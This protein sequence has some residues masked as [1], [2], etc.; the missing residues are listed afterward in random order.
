MATVFGFIL[1]VFT[2]SFLFFNHI[3]LNNLESILIHEKSN[4]NIINAL[5]LL[6]TAIRRMGEPTNQIFATKNY[7]DE[8][9]YYDKIES[10]L[11][12]EMENFS[13]TLNI[14]NPPPE[15]IKLHISIQEC[16][17]KIKVYSAQL[18]QNFKSGNFERA[19]ELM[20]QSDAQITMSLS[21]ID[22]LRDQYVQR[23]TKS[24]HN[25]SRSVGEIQ[26]NSFFISMFFFM[27]TGV[28]FIFGLL[29]A[30]RKRTEELR[31]AQLL[32]LISNSNDAIISTDFEC[33]I[34]SWNSGAEKLFGFS[35]SEIIG[36]NFKNLL[37]ED[38]KN[39]DLNSI[40]SLLKNKHERQIKIETIQQKK[41]GNRF[42]AEI[43]ATLI[44]AQNVPP[45]LSFIVRDISDQKLK[46]SKM[47]SITDTMHDGLV[48][49]SASGSIIQFNRSALQILGL[50]E[51]QLLGRTSM[52]PNWRSVREDGSPFKGE[53]HPAMVALRTGQKVSNVKMG[54]HLP[55]GELR[56]IRINAVPIDNVDGRRVAATFSDI[57]EQVRSINQI[58]NVFSYSPDL[59][60]ILDNT[61]RIQK[62]SPSVERILGYLE[63]ELDG[64]DFKTLIHPLDIQAS[65]INDEN[66]ENSYAP[67][68]PESRLLHKN[69]SYR[70][71]SWS[72]QK[73]QFTQ[74]FYGTGR[75]ITEIK[76]MEKKNR[77]ILK[78]IDGVSIISTTDVKGRITSVNKN[79]I[80]IS[81]Y[82]EKELIGQ[83][84]RLLNS[85]HHEK[86]FF[87]EMWSTILSGKTW[88]GT[89]KN[90]KK[91][92][93]LYYVRSV[94]TPLLDINGKIQEFISIRFD[95]TQQIQF[96]EELL[97]AQK[98]AK[99]GSWRFDLLTFEQTW[100]SETY[101][102]FEI[103]EPQ[104]AEN[105]HRLYREKIHPEDLI[106]LD[107][108]IQNAIEKGEN[109]IYNHRVLLEGG[110][111][112]KYI[113]GVGTI[114]KDKMG[115]PIMLHGTAQDLTEVVSLQNENRFILDTMGIGIWKFN[116]LT[117]DLTWDRSL[118]HLYE[119]D[120]KDFS[121][122]YDA[123]E[124]SL[125]P[126]AKEKAIED[127]QAALKGEREFNT[128]FQIHTKKGNSKY[129]GGRA[130][131][132]R[133]E[134]KEPI[135][136]YGINWDRTRDV[137]LEK[138]LEFERAKSLHNA[139]LASLGEM[140][141]GIAHEVNNPLAVIIANVPLIRKF[142][143]DEVK[144][145]N[146]L[147]SVLKSAN[148]IEKIVKG[149]RKFSR[150]TE[151]SVH[152]PEKLADIISEAMVITENRCRKTDVIVSVKVDPLIKI[153]CDSVEIEQV[154]V[155][156]I[157]NASDA[158]K[159]REERWIKIEAE[160]I[161][162]GIRI[163]FID[164]GRGIPV[165][166]EQKLFQPFFTTKPVGEGTGLG[167]SITKGI[168]DQHKATIV[169]NREIP[170]TCFEITF[171][172]PN[173]SSQ[174]A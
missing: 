25:Y 36:K 138:N 2:G 162:L 13:A 157:N 119:L 34:L 123:W 54:L 147:E 56:W 149:L 159:I 59:M 51:D 82:S 1:V 174:A 6:S 146:K 84:H 67:F 8:K 151:H 100:S 48:I 79:F 42:D 98:T 107:Q 91:D 93:S 129:I 76:M 77:E 68:P 21:I 15:Q 143:S 114:I 60:C 153:E 137:E 108:I 92:G 101:R 80:K 94:V 96:Q 27:I 19:S 30:R 89:V 12:H 28:T 69:G 164:S 74:F 99:I 130:V 23:Q 167:L 37:P 14:E 104:T 66:I 156:L 20:A 116:P 131:V 132:L 118:Y 172:L 5:N 173:T 163:R 81:G 139:K 10:D 109:F 105:L 3:K 133:N 11:N 55:N 31:N 169:V 4:T 120:P 124:K 170:N 78:A 141:A 35:S 90:K 136:M 50:S 134:N 73:D 97:E 41:N 49:Q 154:F 126:S 166:V 46:E 38:I 62:I 75:D 88:I 144:F 148:K 127:L 40:Q 86:S 16:V 57:T 150:T 65:P 71:I 24:F 47:Q 135:L 61:G 45:Q 95:I 111:R 171:P 125:S 33:Q 18:F 140:S 85:D 115:R 70:L 63:N 39:S 32:A 26:R 7:I 17:S 142:K 145:E 72:S 58:Q 155:N 128:T 161:D 165:E 121:G 64:K 103:E 168:L 158:I 52:D 29:L 152:K 44:E 112:L 53:D 43:S 87:K 102:I 160:Q 122:H 106:E 113:R 83:D 117:N 22:N 110:K 9:K